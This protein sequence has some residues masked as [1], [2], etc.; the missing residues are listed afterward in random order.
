M[1]TSCYRLLFI[2][3]LLFGVMSP[4]LTAAEEQ[5]DAGAGSAL[6]LNSVDGYLPLFYQT[7]TGRVLMQVKYLD[8]PLI[9]QTA[10]VSGVGSNDLGLDRG[11][12]GATRIV[13]FRRAGQRVLMIEDNLGFRADSDNPWERAAVEQ[14]FAKSVLASFT[15]VGEN[16]GQ[17][18]VDL[19]PL[20]QAD[21]HGI[22]QRLSASGQGDF[23]LVAD[24]TTVFP[25]Q[26]LNFSR[27]TIIQV[28][29]TYA[30][31]NPGAYV[32]Q[33]TPT[34]NRLSVTYMHQFVALPEAGYQPRAYHPRSGYFAVA[35][36]DYA[37]PLGQ[38][39][40]RQL[41]VR[42]RLRRATDAD[43]A[44]YQPLTYYL[45]R[46][47][48]EPVR[49]ALLEGARWWGEAFAAAGFGDIF[50]VE[51]LP[52]D[53][54]PL[55][56]RYNVI[57]WVHR[58]TRGWS[59][60]ASVVDP[61]TGEII[62]GHVTLGSLRVRQ[63]Q[64]IA[65]ALTAPFSAGRDPLQ[66][67]QAA[68]QMALARLRQLAAH[69]VGH[70]LGL[71]HNFA[72]SSMADRSVMDYPHP[73]LSLDND[74]DVRLDQAYATGVSPWDIWTIRYGYSEFA[75]DDEAARLSQLLDEA[76]QAGYRFISDPDARVGGSPHPAAHLWD[77]GEDPLLRLQ[78]LVAIRQQALSRFGEQVIPVGTPLYELEQRLVP[79]YL[80]HRYQVEAVA[81]L[82][83]GVDY[84]HR[85]RGDDGAALMP[86][87]AAA[88]QLALT[89]LTATL[90]PDFLA[91]PSQLL[92]RIPPPAEGYA[93]DREYFSHH[94]APTFDHLA[95]A[96]AAIDLTLSQML[97]PVRAAR[98]ND[99]HLI[100]AQ[101]PEFTLVLA[102]LRQLAL[103]KHSDDYAAAIQDELRQQLVTRL[104]ALAIDP[105]SPVS[106]RA[107]TIAILETLA[108]D[109]G[110]GKR[111]PDNLVMDYL[112]RQIEGF[113]SEQGKRPTEAPVTPVTVP[114]GSP[115][116]MGKFGAAAVDAGG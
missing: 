19:S 7:T 102:R 69:E 96:R 4:V 50:Q 64:M 12:L 21:S 97:H 37:A 32:Q 41:L 36:R 5:P 56:V 18:L 86:V 16:E 74:G 60:G 67:Q 55:D 47:T 14:A 77:N 70:T 22:G 89:L 98:M 35:Y 78:E 104:L 76:D 105:Q 30:A 106:V 61:R 62:K 52:E 27:N 66:A 33:V 81:K 91:L 92:N 103:S 39:L 49:S 59:Y 26:L 101:L 15:V 54:H 71:S 85:L 43:T 13:R 115:I 3:V 82:L 83:G 72:A 9:Y 99:Q 11:Q 6:E 1:L 108:D 63:D 42:H 107:Q 95:P 65:E 58:A 114:P 17:P 94:T 25:D 2:A 51:L 28:L 88:Q 112:R 100:N 110:R 79:V 46:G 24:A 29:L 116:G 48:P 31:N 40:D 23:S 34:P 8:Q 80:L 38:S 93:R 45:D 87:E 109:F 10:L 113:L 84:D 53:A 111:R 73:N 44:A 75:A 90:E 68:Q 20:L 57:Q